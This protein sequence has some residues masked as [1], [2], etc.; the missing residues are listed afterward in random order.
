LDSYYLRLKRVLKGIALRVKL[1]IALEFLLRLTSVFLI[2]LLGTLF[3]QEA[4]EIFPYLPFVYYL[5]ASISLVLVFLLGLWRIASGLS[6]HRVARGLEEKFPRLKDDVTNSLLLFHQINRPSESDQISEGLVTAHLRKTTDGVSEIHPKQVVNFRRALSHLRLLLPL[7]FA[8]TV[9]LGLDPQFPNRSLAFIFNPF[10]ALPARET[11][12][13][14]E[15]APSIVLRGTPVMVKAKAT[16][17]VPDRL[18]LRLWPEKG[19]VIRLDMES[20]GNGSFTRLI[21]SAQTSFQYQ[22]FS[23]RANSPV[24]GVRVVDAP[25]IGKMKLTLIPPAYTRLPR[26][27]KEEGHIEAIKGTVVNLEAFFIQVPISYRSEM[28][29]D[30]RTPIPSSTGSI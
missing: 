27:V 9:V 19:D 29:W 4:T 13:S 3:V 14:V 24:Y 15:P 17:Y 10:S 23:S 5:L 12:I 18:S 6:M 28:N 7:F 21:A 11:F 8:F 20:E 2:I 16:G 22:A 25:D 26:E 30:S 1:F